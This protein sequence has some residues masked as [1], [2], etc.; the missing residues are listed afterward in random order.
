VKLADRTTPMWLHD[1]EMTT[2]SGLAIDLTDRQDA[3]QEAFSRIWSGELE[4]DGLNRLVLLAGLDWRQVAV[5]RAYAR[6]LRQA[7]FAFSPEIIENTLAAHAGITRLIVRLFL[8]LHD[9]ARHEEGEL[10]GRGLLVEIEHALDAVENLDED[11]ILR[12][13][14]NL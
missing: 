7:R 12:R 1:F 11:R 4:D 3:F 5:L 9:P 8:A 10:A 6:F 14:V 2:R 13:F